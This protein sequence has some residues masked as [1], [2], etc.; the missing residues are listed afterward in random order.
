MFHDSLGMLLVYVILSCRRIQLNVTTP[1]RKCIIFNDIY[2]AD[3]QYFLPFMFC[4]D[5]Y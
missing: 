5:R 2:I 3:R 4:P 1:M